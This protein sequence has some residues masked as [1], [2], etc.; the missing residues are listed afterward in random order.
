MTSGMQGN[1]GGMDAKRLDRPVEHDL[2]AVDAEAAGGDDLGDVARGHRAVELAGVAGLPDGEEGLAVELG[3]HGL[4]FLLQLEVAR[5]ELGA[6]LLEARQVLLG[7]AQR[8]LLR[9]QEI[10]RI[11]VLDVDDVAHLAEAADALEKDDLHECAP[12]SL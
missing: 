7:G 1:L 3:R 12:F 2:A 5:L 9:Q 11:A 10:A 8:L 4:G 6:V